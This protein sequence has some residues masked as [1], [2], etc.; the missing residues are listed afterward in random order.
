MA[1]WPDEYCWELGGKLPRQASWTTET[2]TRMQVTACVPA[3]G[4]YPTGGSWQCTQGTCLLGC[5]MQA[6]GLAEEILKQDPHSAMS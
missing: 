2:D 5:E 4:F 6:E 3:Q 1:P